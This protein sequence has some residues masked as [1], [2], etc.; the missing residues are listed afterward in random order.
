MAKKSKKA[1][2]KPRYPFQNGYLQKKR[3][4]LV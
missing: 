4:L 3:L 2:K 1:D